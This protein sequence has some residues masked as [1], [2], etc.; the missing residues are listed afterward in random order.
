M[1]TEKG[2]QMCRLNVYLSV[3]MKGEVGLGVDASG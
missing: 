2:I 1:G 3:F